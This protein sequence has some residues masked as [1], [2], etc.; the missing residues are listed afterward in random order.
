MVVGGMLAAG[1]GRVPEFSFGSFLQD[2]GHVFIVQKT[3]APELIYCV[4]HP[5]ES[6]V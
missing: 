4:G 6:T 3:F 2:R 5:H 1:S